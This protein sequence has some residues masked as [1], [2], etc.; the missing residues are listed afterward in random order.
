MSDVEAKILS[1]QSKVE[2]EERSARLAY[3]KGDK[4]LALRL[5]KKSKLS[6]RRLAA[7]N[8]TL[9]SIAAQADALETA[10]L[11]TELVSA[12]STSNSVLKKTF[13]GKGRASLVSNAESAADDAAEARDALDDLQAALAEVGASSADADDDELLEELE[14]MA[15]TEITG[16]DALR[17][18]TRIAA[19]RRANVADAASFPSA[20][21]SQPLQVEEVAVTVGSG[22]V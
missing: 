10:A 5:L 2:E 9:S 1:A 15:S 14:G 8:A 16:R 18:A 3:Q 17:E 6:G 13:G 20:P 11:Q 4:A 7:L 12:L 22:A 19:E 21:T